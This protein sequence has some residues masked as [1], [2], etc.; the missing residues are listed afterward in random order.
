LSKKLAARKNIFDDDEG[1]VAEE[2]LKTTVLFKQ[3]HQ[4]Q[5]LLP[6]LTKTIQLNRHKDA[7]N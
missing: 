4:F 2:V 1:T 5:Q 6:I 3:P 7:Y